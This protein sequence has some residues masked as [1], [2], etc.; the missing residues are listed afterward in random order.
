MLKKRE[1]KMKKL[2]IFL[3]PLIVSIPVFAKEKS[4]FTENFSLIKY[5]EANNRKV[6]EIDIFSERTHVLGVNA[7]ENRM[8]NWWDKSN[9]RYGPQQYLS[10]EEESESLAEFYLKRLAERS[11]KARKIG[12]PIALVAGGG[13]IAWGASLTSKEREGGAWDVDIT[14]IFGYL[15]IIMG[16]GCVVGGA[17]TLAI[18]SRAER[19]LKKVISISDLVQRERASHEALSLFAARGRKNRI[20]SGILSAA[21]SVEYLLDIADTSSEYNKGTY[22]YVGAAIWTALAVYSFVVKSPAERAFEDYL[23]ERKKEQQK[24]LQFRLGIMPRGGVQ[25]GF[26]Y[27]F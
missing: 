8:Q 14:P 19:E 21:Y 10:S 23:K 17:L 6:F 27:S 1:S 11:K 9:I 25:V 4:S 22:V 13:L 12:G 7:F 16:A 20:L 15:S 2:I 26:V 5:S 18:P 24:Q 3:I